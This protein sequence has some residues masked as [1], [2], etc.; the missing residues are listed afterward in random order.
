MR[1]LQQ[2]GRRYF[3]T[4]VCLVPNGRAH[5]GHVAGPL[6]KMDVYR[7]H[8][9]RA[10]ADVRMISM[11]D[12][13]EAHVLIK[14]YQEGSTPEDVANRFHD[15][16]V[17]DL[18][19]L[20]IAYD[21]LLNPLDPE[22]ADTYDRINREFLDG[23]IRAGNARVKSEQLPMLAEAT[24]VNAKGV[25]LRPQVGDP[26]VSG[27]LKGRCPLCG[28]GLVGFFCEAC[29]GHFAPGQML[30]PSTA[31]FSGKLRFEER[32]SLW[33]DLKGGA[34]EIVAYLKRI[35]VRADFLEIT[36]CYLR[37]NGA[38]IRLEV[39]SPWG[40]HLDVPG[41]SPGQVI[42]S[43]SSLLIGC[44]LVAGERYKQITGSDVNPFA[45]DSGVTCVLAFGID[46]TVPFLV[47]AVGCALG[48]EEYKPVDHFLVNYFYDLDGGKFSTS[49]GHVIWGGD[50]V[51][52]GG[53]NVDLV[54]AYLC[55]R[56]PE[57]ERAMFSVDEFVRFHN[58]SASR[59]LAAT[60]AAG[61]AATSARSY[62][63]GI[64]RY[65]GAEMLTQSTALDPATFD[66]AAAYS[67]VDRWIHRASAFS[68][69]PEAARTWLM[70]FA[71]LGYPI[72][73][74]AAQEAWTWLGLSGQPSLA[75]IE[76]AAG[77][78]PAH[79]QNVPVS[80]IPELTWAN[81]NASLPVAL[82]RSA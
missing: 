78:S 60:T 69:T 58:D 82:R 20:D 33:L 41:T 15:G 28:E 72:M 81:L 18:K 35:N 38:S 57:F 70:G 56:N 13:H 23:I 36:E 21:D 44:H 37:T 7:R 2:T 74:R 25:S 16:I 6:L 46:N 52:L 42:F 55:W 47:G 51:T 63:D 1:D 65:L 31:H 61:R 64:M 59:L 75:G 12:V 77:V 49:R 73:S 32:S 76:D 8:L 17:G 19:A 24:D 11:S 71:V 68:L 29:G 27:W 9:V 14:A 79:G 66:I 22:W 80:S 62:D 10:G 53:A 5:L 34:A 48:Q 3:L 43:Y 67:C 54:R 39:P 4:P 50:I 26:V 30:E 40:L 45:V